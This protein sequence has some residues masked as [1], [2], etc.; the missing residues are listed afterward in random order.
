ML[1]HH[2][3]LNKGKEADISTDTYKSVRQW[4]ERLKRI[5]WDLCQT[6]VDPLCCVLFYLWDGG[7]GFSLV[8][9]L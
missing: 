6:K 1:L 2:I 9:P 8:S 3:S 7:D 5:N 4:K